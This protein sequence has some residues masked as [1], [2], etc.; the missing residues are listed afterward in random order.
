M[1]RHA[2]CCAALLAAGC[3]PVDL[4]TRGP[5][6]AVSHTPAFTLVG[7][8][9]DVPRELEASEARD[10]YP[11]ADIVWR[12]D[13]PGDRHVQVE[14]IFRDAA[15]DAA[16][17]LARGPSVVAH[18]EVER[19]HSLTERARAYTGGDHD[20]KFVLTLVEAGTGRTLLGPK[21]VHTVL[22]AWGGRRAIEAEQRGEGMRAR[23]VPHLAG[24]LRK[25]MSVPVSGLGPDARVAATLGHR[26]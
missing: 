1:I 16:R 18:I 20:M 26:L 21:P 22:D 15:E 5:A 8:E 13:G 12:G 19:F 11:I 10:L 4:S 7:V 24:V 17:S 3:T 6:P 9:I 14:R 25:L 2:L 23:I